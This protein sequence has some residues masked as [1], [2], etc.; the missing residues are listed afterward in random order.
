MAF[1]RLVC[2]LPKVLQ[3]RVSTH[4]QTFKTMYQ[5][6]I[7]END[8]IRDLKMRQNTGNKRVPVDGTTYFLISV[9]GVMA[10]ILGR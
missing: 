10:A 2:A 4:G 3:Q 1:S 9:K 8:S 6:Q 7:F 5:V